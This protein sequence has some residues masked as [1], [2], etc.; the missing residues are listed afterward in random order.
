MLEYLTLILICQLV[1]EFAVTGGNLPIPGPVAGMVFLF[2]FLVIK[3][4]VPDELT[5]VTNTLLNNL[6]LLFVPAGV[7]VMAH[8]KLFGADAVPLSVALLL[9]TVLTIIVTASVMILIN[10]R[11]LNSTSTPDVEDE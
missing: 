6:S 2:L 1:G 7:G 5:S 3:G 9:S 8:F 4:E 10:R 11:T